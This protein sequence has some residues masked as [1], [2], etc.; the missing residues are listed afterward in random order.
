MSTVSEIK[1][2]PNC[3][4][5]D[6]HPES[7]GRRSVFHAVACPRCKMT[8]PQS[9]DEADAIAAWNRLS[10]AAALARA[11]ERIETLMRASGETDERQLLC[12]A[13]GE[14]IFADIGIVPDGVVLSKVQ[15]RAKAATLAAALIVLAGE[16][17]E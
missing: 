7:I 13:V 5:C 12:D 3:G 17:G 15:Q 14:R 9:H 8:G 2:C 1:P 11:V 6:E 10:N 16:V 4:P